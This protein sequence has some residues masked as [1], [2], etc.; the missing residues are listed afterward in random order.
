MRPRMNPAVR[1]VP[2]PD[3]VYLYGDRAART[4][5]GARAY[6]WLSRLAPYLDGATDMEDLTAGLPESQRGTVENLV[7]LLHQHGFVTDART[8]RPHRLSTAESEVY[9]R[10][11]AFIACAMDSPEYRFQRHRE[12]PVTI[13]SSAGTTAVTAAVIEAGMRSGWVDVRVVAA[14]PDALAG[15]GGWRDERQRV[16]VEPGRVT[17]VDSGVILQISCVPEELIAGVREYRGREVALGQILVGPDEAWTTE[18]GHPDDTAAAGAWRRLAGTRHDAV[19]SRPNRWLTGPVPA[20]LAAHLVLACFRHRTGMDTLPTPGPRVPRL[21]R[22]DLRTVEMTQHPVDFRGEPA[23]TST[24]LVGAATEL[25]DEFTGALVEFGEQHLPQFPLALSRAVVSDPHRV[26]PEEVPLPEVFGWGPDPDSAHTRTMLR[27]LAL[28]GWLSAVGQQAGED[29]I[30]G[31]TIE[32][33]PVPTSAVPVGLA[34]GLTRAGALEWGLRQ[35]CEAL[36]T[37]RRPEWSNEPAVPP[38]SGNEPIAGLRQQLEVLG[39]PVTVVDLTELLG[40]SAYAVRAGALPEVVSCAASRE[41]ALRDGLERALL[42][43]QGHTSAHC[44]ADPA[45]SANDAE[46]LVKAVHAAG[47]RPLALELAAPAIPH[48]V[49]VV[50]DAE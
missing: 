20:M 33:A 13:L 26:L 37:A 36:L 22:L 10:E 29:L 40:I 16:V 3:G 32:R 9:A 28:Y 50:L 21:T 23:V 7:A 2:C 48:L 1:Y 17:E 6:E 25:V 44:A 38:D 5:R 42:A 19:E 14:E 24:D 39:H 46:L 31:E 27:A 49:Q 34:A 18:V 15:T 43:W 11:I 30:T 41:T 12:G 4:L 45:A 35:H 8:D 47:F